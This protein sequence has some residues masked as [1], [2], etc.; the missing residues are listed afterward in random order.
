MVLR[1]RLED[2]R[3]DYVS[4]QA[5]DD[6]IER[7]RIVMFFRPSEKKWVDVSADPIRKKRGIFYIGPERRNPPA[8]DLFE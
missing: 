1:V 6:L 8:P 2:D 5:I 3:Y 7:K 4:A